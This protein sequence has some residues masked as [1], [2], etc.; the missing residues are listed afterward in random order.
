MILDKLRK[1]VRSIN[2]NHSTIYSDIAA[3][4]KADLATMLIA[5]IYHNLV[6]A[7]AKLNEELPYATLLSLT[8]SLIESNGISHKCVNGMI[9]ELE[10]EDSEAN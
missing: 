3:L 7:E 6:L 5:L 2:E 1:D 10:N 9:K 4:R 8:Y